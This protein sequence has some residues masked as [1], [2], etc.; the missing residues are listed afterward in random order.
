MFDWY[1]AFVA[2]LVV[3]HISMIC[4]TVY[5]HRCLA[6]RSFHVTNIGEHFFRFFLWFCSGRIVQGQEKYWAAFH[7]R[8]HKYSD[9]ED[10]Q[11]SPYRY[12][13]KQFMTSKQ[14]KPGEAAYISKQDI[15]KYTPDLNPVQYWMDGNIYCKYPN[16]GLNIIWIGYTIIS[17]WPGFIL[18]MVY[19]F[20]P[21]GLGSV[22]RFYIGHKIAGYRYVKDKKGD[23]SRNVGPWGIVFGGEELHENHHLDPGNPTFSRRWYEFDLGYAYTFLFR[24][25]G[26]LK[27][28]DRTQT[29]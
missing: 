15:K 10:D 20:Y 7:R 3:F 26:L 6:H 27:L 24:A 29:K 18:G 14:D 25:L 21:H 2:H 22:I 9:T 8:H 11:Q 17:G 16:L 1:W 19:R 28:A 23:L 4:Y 12:T 5:L 13:F